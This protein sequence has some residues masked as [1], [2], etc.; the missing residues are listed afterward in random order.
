M[1]RDRITLTGVRARGHHGVLDHEKR[2]GQDF[3][4]D[5]VL[6]LDLADAAATDDLT[7]T[8]SYAE[9]AADV[10]ARVEG[11]S[12]DLIETLAG[13][14]AQDALA[15]DLVERV[16]VTVHKPQA[17][18]G[19]PFGDVAV[20]VVRERQPVLAVVAL[21]SNLPVP[22]DAPLGYVPDGLVATVLDAAERLFG[23]GT[24]V[25][26]GQ[27]VESD[28][29]GGPDQ[30][31]Y[32]NTVALLST[33]LPPRALLAGLHRI[34]ALFSRT[35]EVRWGPR[36]LDLDLV[37]HGDPREGTDILSDDPELTLPH[38][39]AHG[40]AFVLVPWLDADPDAVLRVDGEV[41]RVADL[42]AR[43]DVSGI[44]RVTG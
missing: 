1:S 32:V 25:A 33:T 10:V 41:R 9:V 16:E 18:V 34:E 23:L 39:R 29:V 2:D 44:R 37:Q 31:P 6:D 36:T 4:V 40:R 26:V 28:P 15:R 8:V 17:P 5:V 7:R 14:I 21:G 20:T 35:R 12:L 13:Q 43:L 19:V 42:V 11:P 27:V 22:P 38:P 24:L 3:V 30:P